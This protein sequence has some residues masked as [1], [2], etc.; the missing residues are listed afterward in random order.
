MV[1]FTDTPPL[2]AAAVIQVVFPAC[3]GDH[4]FVLVVE[5]RA[6]RVLVYDSLRREGAYASQVEV[7][8]AHVD[9]V[10]PGRVPCPKNPNVIFPRSVTWKIEYPNC[11]QQSNLNDCG[12]FAAH[13]L[14][15]VARGLD[16]ATE[17]WSPDAMRMEMRT[18]LRTVALV[19]HLI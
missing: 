4:W 17:P 2:A 1:C 13:V 6:A 12:V 8:T 19:P 18:L 11:P 9:F 10:R 5:H 3:H 15:C 14:R 16:P 7:I